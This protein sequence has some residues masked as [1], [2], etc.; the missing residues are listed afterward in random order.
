[1]FDQF[2]FVIPSKKRI[3]LPKIERLATKHIVGLPNKWLQ[4]LLRIAR[5][6][7]KL[8]AKKSGSRVV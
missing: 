2:F 6:D 5:F 8:L 7:T 4:L 3:K 1:M